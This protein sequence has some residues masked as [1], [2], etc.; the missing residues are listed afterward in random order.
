MRIVER[1]ARRLIIEDTHS[2]AYRLGIVVAI[3]GMAMA[4]SSAES[5]DIATWVQVFFSPRNVPFL[6]F[7]TIAFVIYAYL[8]A[9]KKTF[10]LDK[11]RQRAE[12]VEAL[13]I[14][15]RR[16]EI[17]L[18]HISHVQLRRAVGPWRFWGG[19]GGGGRTGGRRRPFELE[20]VLKNRRLWTIW[21]APEAN[22]V[23]AREISEFLGVELERMDGI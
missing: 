11:D 9:V 1:T 3:F 7:L 10:T 17:P 23:R 12:L 14:G 16:K 20:I 2:P 18:S 13:F 15:L 4:I 8:L 19:F 22:A 21:N 6:V 5:G